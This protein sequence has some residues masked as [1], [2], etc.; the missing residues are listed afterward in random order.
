MTRNCNIT[1]DEAIEALEADGW[2]HLRHSGYYRGPGGEMAFIAHQN[3]KLME[4]W[5]FRNRNLAYT[6]NWDYVLRFTR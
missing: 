1:P 3:P 5:F 4:I 6:G 2:N